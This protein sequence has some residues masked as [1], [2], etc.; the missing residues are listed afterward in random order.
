VHRRS[1]LLSSVALAACAA[2]PRP[3][4]H[5]S[6][7]RRLA[8]TM[9]D[10]NVEVTP[11]L[12]AVA[13]DAAIRQT[14][15]ARSR[16]AMLF[17]CGMRV[18]SPEGGDLLARWSAERHALGNHSYSHRYF[19]S[20]KMTLADFVAELEK[21]EAIV[22]PY[23]AFRRR[24]RFP[25]LKE[26]DTVEKRDGARAALA[27]RGYTNGHVTID[28]SDWAFDSRLR[29]RLTREPAADVAPFRDA[30]LAHMLD[31]ARYYD[32]LARAAVGRAIA[33]TMLVHHSLLNAL[34][35]GDLLGALEKDGWTIVDADEA[36]EDPIFQSA[37]SVLPAG[38]SLVWSLAKENAALAPT[39]R[40]PGEDEDYEKA[41]L[42]RLEPAG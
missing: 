39:L 11:A 19:H 5:A 34:F 24:F 6:S 17:V 12:T 28:A 10:P 36:Y 30:Y 9:D 2:A 31:R 13:R 20:A 4:A 14:L 27:A 32:G 42:D 1:F 15:A 26:G 33:H 29:K 16:Q 3:P 21:G 23:G 41:T 25:F 38:E 7:A 18:E 35:L 37:P 8:L 22:R 40:Y